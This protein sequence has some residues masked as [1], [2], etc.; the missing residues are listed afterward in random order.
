MRCLLG[1]EEGAGEGLADRLA[2]FGLTEP[3][4]CGSGKERVKVIAEHRVQRRAF[5]ITLLGFEAC[6]FHSWKWIWGLLKSEGSPFPL[7]TP[8]FFPV[9][10]IKAWSVQRREGFSDTP[11]VY[12]HPCQ[13]LWQV[14]MLHTRVKRR[15]G[16]RSMCEQHVL[17]ESTPSVLTNF[18]IA[19][20]LDKRMM[21]VW[22]EKDIMILLYFFIPAKI[23]MSHTF[24]LN[25]NKT[26]INIYIL[27]YKYK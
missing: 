2:R 6:D 9:P 16:L 8:R 21:K 24:K 17:K 15:K 18:L 13:T 5:V 23:R 14:K 20:D 22:Y 19:T 4:V 7:L 1:A 26:K 12:G 10:L 11:L 27:Q 25:I 3:G